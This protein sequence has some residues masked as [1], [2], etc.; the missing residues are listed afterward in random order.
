M[1]KLSLPGPILEDICC[2]WRSKLHP[3]SRWGQWGMGCC[4]FSEIDAGL[5]ATIELNL[6]ILVA[7]IP[8]FRPLLGKIS[9]DYSAKR[10][11]ING[12]SSG[13]FS[14]YPLSRIKN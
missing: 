8:T 10:S 12:S 7:S 1:S 11:G 13:G 4:C 14:E 6:W 9:R 2:R 5:W 3:S